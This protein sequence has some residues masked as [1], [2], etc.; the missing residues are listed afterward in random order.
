LF[1]KALEFMNE[2]KPIS[3]EETGK[4]IAL[5]KNTKPIFMHA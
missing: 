5:A 3:E 4:L 1:L 2:Y